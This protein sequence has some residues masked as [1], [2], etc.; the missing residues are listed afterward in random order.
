M[1]NY[2]IPLLARAS[3]RG[4]ARCEGEVAQVPGDLRVQGAGMGLKHDLDT[5]S[6]VS[7]MLAR[8]ERCVFQSL[9]SDCQVLFA[10]DL[11][12]Y[13]HFTIDMLN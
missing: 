1:L 8:T 12:E 2:K 5:V 9:A 4:L 6:T 11:L 13:I 10:Q 3:L 7:M